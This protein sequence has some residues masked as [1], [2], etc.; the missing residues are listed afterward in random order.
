MSA[1]D[2]WQNI[3][4]VRRAARRH[5]HRIV[6]EYIDG[7]ADDEETMRRNVSDFDDYALMHRVL[8]DVSDV[9]TST[10]V[11]GERV[12]HP[13]FFSPS[14]S[15][16]LFHPEGE[17]AVARVAAESGIA[18][19]L[20]T[21]SSVTIEDIAA[22]GPSPRWFQVYAFKD[23]GLVR[24]LIGRAKAAGYTALLL[25][26]DHPFS[27][28]RERD[29]RS[30]FS[31]PPRIGV[32]QALD[33]LARPAWL[34]EHLRS[35]PVA[36]ANIASTTDAHTLAE[37]VQRKLRADFTWDDAEWL[38][39]EWGGMAVIKGVLHPLDARR[40]ISTG[41]GGVMVSNHGG[42]QLDG[43]ASPISA[44]RPVLDAVA[45]DVDVVLDG[46]IR[47]GKHVMKAIAMGAKAVSFARPYLY[48]L[49]AAGTPG[50]RRATEILV[51]EFKLDMA[52]A[53]VRTV[54]EIDAT[55]LMN[56]GRAR[57]QQEAPAAGPA[58][59]V[60]AVPAI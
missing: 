19:S 11:F 22:I 25:T 49:C 12:S 51:N 33:A 38:L 10:T 35:P 26:V 16:R 8:V 14:A 31:V 57:Q 6:Y 17:A 59:A 50:V 24:E 32:R 21:L 56:G 20:S 44:L 18:Y 48:G 39:G 13:F 30:G 28:N 7:G 60:E 27:G 41:F 37:F 54:A 34:W 52:L 1:I 42:R 36:F 53:G 5:A 2:K 9:D 46:G 3:E 4:D 45:G 43:A 23:R 47:R 15:N 29:K 58:E 55:L 40:A